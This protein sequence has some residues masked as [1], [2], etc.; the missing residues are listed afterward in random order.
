M[1][2]LQSL[3]TLGLCGSELWNSTE[4]LCYLIDSLAS[5]QVAP[6]K[7]LEEVQPPL[8]HVDCG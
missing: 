2:S 7:G 5:G 1:D 8:L 3:P 4:L 6:G